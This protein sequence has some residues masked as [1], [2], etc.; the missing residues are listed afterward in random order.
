[1]KTVKSPTR[2][3]WKELVKRPDFE[4][5]SIEETVREIL[6][7]VKRSGDD[8]VLEYAKKFDDLSED[9][10]VLETARESIELSE[11]LKEAI[12]IAINNIEK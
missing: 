6:S 3:D 7:A 9:N 8:A 1:M 4:T 12:D 10:F 5:E 11:N 2:A